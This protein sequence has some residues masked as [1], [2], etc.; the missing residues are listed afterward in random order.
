MNKNNI[1]KDILCYSVEISKE[2][3]ELYLDNLYD[4]EIIKSIP[5]INIITSTLELKESISNYLFCKKLAYFIFNI[6]D[7]SYNKR[8]KL[9]NKITKDD[10]YFHE[11]L[12]I[13][14]DKFDEVKK[15]DYLARLLKGYMNEIIDYSEF[16]RI[17]LILTQIYIEDIEYLENHIT[18]EYVYGVTGRSLYTVGLVMNVMFP[19]A[20]N[21]EN[22]YEEGFQ[23]TS[24]AK[25]V[26]KC[27]F[28]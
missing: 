22:D 13:V 5:V 9:Y 16:R 17:S 1:G 19:G 12:F 4:S 7:I 3:I 27:L 28:E 21:S 14:L 6:Q 24:L 25:K 15:A 2:C 20:I 11:K 26:Y 23:Y 18:D 8:V 10:K